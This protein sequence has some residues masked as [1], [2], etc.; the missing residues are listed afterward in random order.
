M[1]GAASVLGRFA[2]WQSCSHYQRGWL[3]LGLRKHADGEAIKPG[4]VV[5]SMSGQTIEILNTY[6]KSLR[7]S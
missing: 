3:D 6:D 5:T 4:Y 2:L 1:C 7:C